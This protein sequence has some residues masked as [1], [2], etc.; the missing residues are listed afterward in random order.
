MRQQAANIEQSFERTL[1]SATAT[2]KQKE[3]AALKLI[4]VLDGLSQRNLPAHEE[5]AILEKC[6][7]TS[8]R[9]GKL[10]MLGWRN[11]ETN[12][13]EQIPR[14]A[15]RAHVLLFAKATGV[16]PLPRREIPER[17]GTS[18]EDAWI[19]NACAASE[20]D[21]VA[22]AKAA[23]MKGLA[24]SLASPYTTDL[25]NFYRTSNA[26]NAGWAPIPK[27][28]LFQ[29]LPQWQLALIAP[30]ALPGLKA[31]PFANSR[32]LEA[33]LLNN[34]RGAQIRQDIPHGA[35]PSYFGGLDAKSSVPDPLVDLITRYADEFPDQP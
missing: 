8:S 27:D 10:D 20:V 4:I 21:T 17:D 31:Y 34:A 12:N 29:G 1:A 22:Y 2:P 18:Y 26:A 24:G 30:N 28:R 35:M 25:N 15:L 14:I 5:L 9:V 19:G 33:A 16:T 7:Y 13:F 6:V 23:I 3:R 32:D 11:E